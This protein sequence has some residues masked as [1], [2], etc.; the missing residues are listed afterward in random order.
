MWKTRKSG[1]ENVDVDEH[2]SLSSKGRWMFDVSSP[3]AGHNQMMRL[4]MVD[5]V[6]YPV[7]NPQMSST[8][9]LNVSRCG[10]W[11]GPASTALVTDRLSGQSMLAGWL[12]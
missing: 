7:D 8:A 4:M 12:C 6:D 9:L 5:D 10:A 11:L 3:A 1:V 2:W